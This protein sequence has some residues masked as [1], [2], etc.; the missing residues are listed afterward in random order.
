MKRLFILLFI[1]ALG[2]GYS[3][4]RFIHLGIKGGVNFSNFNG[5]IHNID[6]STRSSY[7]IGIFTQFRLIGT[8]S[9]MPEIVYSA[10]GAKVESGNVLKDFKLDYLTFPMVIS[11]DILPN[12]LNLDIGPQFGI[13]TN[14][15]FKHVVKTE[16]FDFAAL[17]GLT[18]HLSKN[19]FIQG[20]YIAGL[21][22]FSRRADVKNTNIQLSLGARF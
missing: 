7:H 21:S 9:F 14:S 1:L 12:R 17:G 8:V 4:N 19:F 10:Q 22:H 15:N 13:L 16:S 11:V 2:T 5:N 3:Q 18:I 20:R 6:F